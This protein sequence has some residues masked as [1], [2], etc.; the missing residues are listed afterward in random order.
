MFYA[1][2]GVGACF[3]PV[4]KWAAAAFK[5]MSDDTKQHASWGAAFR[6]AVP[7]GLSQQYFNVHKNGQHSPAVQEGQHVQVGADEQRPA[8]QDSGSTTRLEGQVPLAKVSTRSLACPTA[9]N[10][11]Q[12]GSRLLLFVPPL[13]AA[14]HSHLQCHTSGLWSNWFCALSASMASL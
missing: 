2:L 12:G 3:R 7:S 9:T 6:Y 1:H 10:Q 14:C 13:S 4:P 5:H 11:Q 8:S